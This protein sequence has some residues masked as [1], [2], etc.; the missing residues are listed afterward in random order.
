MRALWCPFLLTLF[1]V[2]PALAAAVTLEF[3]GARAF[4]EP[5]LREALADPLE[6]I[7]REGLTP[8]TA[9]DAAFFLELFYRRHGFS[10]ALVTAT[11]QSRDR[12]RLSVDEGVKLRLGEVKFVGARGLP[13]TRLRDYFLAPTRSREAAGALVLPYI[14]GDL[15]SGLQTLQTL[16]ES[17]GY[18]QARVQLIPPRVRGETVDLT[19]LVREGRQSRFGPVRLTGLPTAEPVRP[20]VWWRRLLAKRDLLSPRQ[21]LEVGLAELSAGPY[22]P[23]TA[24]AMAQKVAEYLKSRGHYSATARAV[25][26]RSRNGRVPV[27]IAARPGPVLRFGDVRVT[28]T[29]RLKPAYVRNRFLA[30]QGQRY[31]PERLDEVFSDEMRTGLFQN[32]R[33]APQPEPDGTLRLDVAVTEAKAREFGVS[34]GFSSFDGPIFGVE[35]RDRNFRG[36]GR[37]LSL[38]ADYSAR[39]LAGEIL[40][41]DPHL[42]ETDNRFRAR[43]SLAT[44]DL[45][46]YTK[47]EIGLLLSLSRRPLKAVELGV[48]AQI[49]A[50]EISELKVAPAEAGRLKY[51]IPSLGATLSLDGRD[52]PLNPLR[53]LAFNASADF[54]AGQFQFLRATARLSYYL[55]LGR[56][57]LSLGLRGSVLRPFNGGGR[58]SIPIDERFFLGGSTTVRSFT[59]R[60]LGPR[61][62]VTGKPT[63]GLTSVTFN[64]EYNF[65]IWKELRGAV[66]YDAGALGRDSGL[67]SIRQGIGAGLRYAL[68]IGPLRIDYG[69]NPSPR[70]GESRGAL[71]IAFGVAF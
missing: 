21:R 26:G 28:G 5:A 38:R 11:I 52:S 27:V 42:F 69:F 20:R 14:A 43:L 2:Q 59:E 63:G 45:D 32:L 16:Y 58:N 1:L 6:S 31:S 33:L 65:P 67:G 12:L 17:E 47:R 39:T 7:D 44:R 35:Y 9:D 49:R 13:E 29:E 10:K 62:A 3:P 51:V 55:Q 53:G 23:A 57:G 25:S 54:S 64:A 56:T 19:V 36:T 71:H 48:F 61:D 41:E 22:T 68:P 15:Q 70:P 24:E 37:P 8:A 50:V 4:A 46:S 60:R 30:L 34:G 40:Y 18:L 66:F